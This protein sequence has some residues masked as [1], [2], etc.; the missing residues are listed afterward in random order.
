MKKRV[1]I[2]SETDAYVGQLAR[3]KNYL[4]K[5][6][7]ISMR[8]MQAS[9]NAVRMP[10]EYAMSDL[11]SLAEGQLFDVLLRCQY[12]SVRQIKTEVMIRLDITQYEIIVKIR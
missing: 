3:S 1:E 7:E 10:R 8:V 2:K 5:H 12:Q 4:S 9:R 11:W 6:G